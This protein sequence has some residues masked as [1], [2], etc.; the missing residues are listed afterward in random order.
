MPKVA[1]EFTPK[2]SIYKGTLEVGLYKCV[3]KKKCVRI[4]DS[5]PLDSIEP[6]SLRNALLYNCC[7]LYTSDAADE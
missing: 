6:L 3:Y 4:C 2:P 1:P 7:L 5:M